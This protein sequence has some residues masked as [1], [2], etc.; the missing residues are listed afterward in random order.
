[1]DAQ[2]PHA[3]LVITF[4]TRPL[5]AL[6]TVDLFQVEKDTRA[7]NTR[8]RLIASSNSNAAKQASRKR[9]S[10]AAQQAAGAKIRMTLLRPAS[11]P[12]E[13]VRNI[14]FE[15]EFDVLEE[16]DDDILTAFESE[17]GDGLAQL[18][19]NNRLRERMECL[20]GTAGRRAVNL[21][22]LPPTDLIYAIVRRKDTG[23][24]GQDALQFESMDQTTMVLKSDFDAK[25]YTG[26]QEPA[27]STVQRDLYDIGYKGFC[28]MGP[29]YRWSTQRFCD[30]PKKPVADL[31]YNQPLQGLADDGT[32]VRDVFRVGSDPGH[33]IETGDS[34]I[35]DKP[36]AIVSGYSNP[37]GDECVL[38]GDSKDILVRSG[39]GVS[40]AFEKC[41][42]QLRDVVTCGG[43]PSMKTCHGFVAGIHDGENGE[44]ELSILL[45]LH[46]GNLPP[47]LHWRRLSQDAILQTNLAAIIPASWVVSKFDISPLTLHPLP[48]FTDTETF[49]IGKPACAINREVFVAGHLDILPGQTRAAQNGPPP[50][51]LWSR[52][53]EN[54]NLKSF[55]LFSE[56]CLRGGEVTDPRFHEH[57]I[58]KERI[59][60]KIQSVSH[61]QPRAEFHRVSPFPPD[62]ALQTICASES[63]FAYPYY[64]PALRDLH[65]AVK[66]FAASKAKKAKNGTGSVCTLQLSISG[67]MLM[68]LVHKY[69]I[70]AA[71]RFKE[72]AI[73]AVM[74]QFHLA[75]ELLGNID[76][77][78]DC[79]GHGMVQLYAPITARWV[80]Y[81]PN[82]NAEDNNFVGSTGRAE[83]EFSRFV[84]M[85]RHGGELTGDINVKDRP[86]ANGG[87]D[88]EAEGG[89]S[90]PPAVPQPPPGGADGAGAAAAGKISCLR[91]AHETDIHEQVAGGWEHLRLLLFLHQRSLNRH[92]AAPTPPSP[93]QQ[94]E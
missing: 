10:A 13:P 6:V 89:C 65:L 5:P 39:M 85:D 41:E 73:E 71:V 15:S 56:F 54:N 87:A 57:A 2:D 25:P 70:V 29:T 37:L 20:A 22:H 67:K 75:E 9:I 53:Y 18:P 19:K 82:A 81:N 84:G 51:G 77:V 68:Q 26:A 80:L 88:G 74:Q 62:M 11:T 76:G 50:S 55:S 28:I 33:D 59:L 86:A 48:E 4:T 32:K 46:K 45:A 12:G 58:W 52:R 27:I 42:S 66:R 31:F 21:A 3:E 49:K 30:I 72:G 7:D 34:W 1:M 43:N 16:M 78:F 60:G 14:V 40:F 79:K 64:S 91:A 92:L 23:A 24:G 8:S 93:R 83:I 61:F 36:L 17:S 69:A 90:G 94:V 63:L 35:E 44:V 47:F 38:A